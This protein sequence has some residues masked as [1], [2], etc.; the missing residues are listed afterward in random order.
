MQA[1]YVHSLL[2]MWKNLAYFCEIWGGGNLIFREN[3]YIDSFA[4][5]FPADI[6]KNHSGWKFSLYSTNIWY[7]R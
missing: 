7:W 3:G 4:A 6:F 2:N 1:I 5:T